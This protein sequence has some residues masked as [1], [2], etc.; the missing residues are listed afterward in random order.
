LKVETDSLIN[1]TIQLEHKISSFKRG[2]EGE[3]EYI[4]IAIQFSI[5]PFCQIKVVVFVGEKGRK[6][7]RI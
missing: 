7:F 5:K 1:Y 6:E 4:T 3:G 2:K